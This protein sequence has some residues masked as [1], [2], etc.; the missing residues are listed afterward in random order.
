MVRPCNATG[1][2]AASV[3]LRWGVHCCRV[4]RDIRFCVLELE[5]ASF[6]FRLNY[7]RNKEEWQAGAQPKGS[8]PLG[9]SQVELLRS[10]EEPVDYRMTVRTQDRLYSFRASLKDLK[11]WISMVRTATLCS[12]ATWSSQELA[13][14]VAL[15][16]VTEDCINAIVQSHMDGRSVA[17]CR[18]VLEMLPRFKLSAEDLQPTSAKFLLAKDVEKMFDLFD[19][20]RL[21]ASTSRLSAAMA[22][23][24]ALE[25][26]G[27]RELSET[28]F[29]QK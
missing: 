11:L 3:I 26:S 23:L 5:P 7:Y 22:N 6:D 2:L 24:E 28:E 19:K 17:N 12:I 4:R 18:S 15:S 21:Y 25:R 20:Y 14:F 8:V 27:T 16:G 29:D 13:S 10:I 1:L 9:I